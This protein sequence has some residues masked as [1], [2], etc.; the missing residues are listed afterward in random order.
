MEPEWKPIGYSRRIVLR[1]VDIIIG[2][3]EVLLGLRVLLH[4]LGANPASEFVA[5][6]YGTTDQ[7]LAPFAGIFP[8]FSL[9]GNY[10]I[11]FTTLFAMLAYAFIGWAILKLI[12]FLTDA[13]LRLD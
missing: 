12:S 4:L 13:V 8:S 10:V 1:F 6:L 9:S 2:I 7:L 11:E 5:W 3:I